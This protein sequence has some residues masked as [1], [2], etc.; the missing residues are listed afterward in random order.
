MLVRVARHEANRTKHTRSLRIRRGLKLAGTS[1][2]ELYQGGDLALTTDYP[3]VL[4]EIL[5][6]YVGSRAMKG[7]FPGY[8]N[9]P[10]QFL[11]LVNA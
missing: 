10:W 11:G 2:G 8:S 5:A 4:G 6:K 3:S 7:V 9:D 1:E